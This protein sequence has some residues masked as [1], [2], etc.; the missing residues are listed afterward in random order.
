MRPLLHQTSGSVDPAAV[1]QLTTLLVGDT[2]AHGNGNG[3]GGGGGGGGSGGG[4]SSAPRPPAAAEGM[5]ALLWLV[6]D[7]SPSYHPMPALLWLVR[8]LS[9]YRPIDPNP[10]PSSH[11]H[12]SPLTFH[13]NQ[14]RDLSTA[15]R[16][17]SGATI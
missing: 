3:N 6:R 10:S 14:V 17:A 4:G 15:L 13:P 7:L 8:D 16:D 2:H 1:R 12:H 11:P 9:T 5:P